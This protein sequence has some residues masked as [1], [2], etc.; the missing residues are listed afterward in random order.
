M[1]FTKHAVDTFISDKIT[2][3]TACNAADLYLEFPDAKNWLSGFGLMVIFND[4]PPENRRHF[5]W[6]FLRR[7]EMALAEYSLAREALQNLLSGNR[8]RWSPYFHALTHFETAL[9][10]LYQALDSY[11]KLSKRNLF[12]SNDDSVEDRLNKIYN[13][14]K[15]QLTTGD[16]LVWISDSGVETAVAAI[17]Y[18]E[19][20][21]L[22]RSLAR[23]A[24]KL[25]S[26]TSPTAS[27]TAEPADEVDRAGI[28]IFEG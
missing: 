19:I 25:S 20:E 8:G 22:L 3:V 4:Q 16:Q 18:V 13:I 23:V 28:A 17:S 7:A 5:A 27:K 15:H 14:S 26:S 11:R 12:E 10:Q 9:A 2:K 24:T 1:P 21:E 6:Q